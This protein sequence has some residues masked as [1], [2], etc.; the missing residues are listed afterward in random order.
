[1]N[2]VIKYKLKQMIKKCL[3]VFMAILACCVNLV[4]LYLLAN[5]LGVIF[6]INEDLLLVFVILLIILLLLF[7]LLIIYFILTIVEII[8]ISW[9]KI[10]VPKI[11]TDE[12]A[13]KQSGN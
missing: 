2:E 9:D 11:L 4:L 7:E 8:N 12:K 13:Q 3:K 1:M 5:Q 6:N 10:E